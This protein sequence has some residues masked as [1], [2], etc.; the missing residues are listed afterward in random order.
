MYC[1]CDKRKANTCNY[2]WGTRVTELY[3]MSVENILFSTSSQLIFSSQHLH[4]VILASSYSM[5]PSTL[6]Y[7]QGRIWKLQNFSCMFSCRLLS[8]SRNYAKQ[9]AIMV[10]II[11]GEINLFP[12]LD[13]AKGLL[14]GMTSNTHKHT[15]SPSLTHKHEMDVEVYRW[16]SSRYCDGFRPSCCEWLMESMIKHN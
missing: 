12:Y 13:M 5:S 11:S 2:L 7:W 10:I 14:I 15:I 3:H 4:N 1:I 6:Y 9:Q 8:R 16:S